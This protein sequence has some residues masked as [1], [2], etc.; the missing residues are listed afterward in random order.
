MYLKTDKNDVQLNKFIDKNIKVLKEA[1]KR[2]GNMNGKKVSNLLKRQVSLYTAKKA[3]DPLFK[4]FKNSKGDEKKKYRDQIVKNMRIIVKIK[5]IL[6][7]FSLKINHIWLKIKKVKRNNKLVT[8]FEI[9]YVPA[10]DF[11]ILLP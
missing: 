11:Q 8:I 10:I 5:L 7:L 2:T 6:M 4:K 3:S 1:N 9:F